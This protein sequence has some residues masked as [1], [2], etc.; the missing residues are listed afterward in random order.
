MKALKTIA[1]GSL[2]ILSGVTFAQSDDSVTI[3]SVS[4]APGDE[5]L[6]PVTVDSNTDGIASIDIDV[7]YDDSQLTPN[8]GGTACGFIDAGDDLD[9]SKHGLA[10]SE[11]SAGVLRVIVNTLPALGNPPVVPLDVGEVVVLRFEIQQGATAPGTILLEAS[12]TD[13]S[14][15]DGD[16]IAGVTFND[17][18][19]AVLDVGPAIGVDPTTIDFG[20]QEQNTTSSAESVRVTNTGNT[21]GLEISGV[22]F[23]GDAVFAL[24][25][26]GCD[27]L[28]LNEGAFCDI[29]FIFSPDD[30]SSFSGMATI[31]SNA[32]DFDVTLEGEGAPG[33][34]GD[35]TISV[36]H[37]FGE[38]LTGE[39][40][41]QHTFT[42][43][44][45]EAGG[46]VVAV[47]TVELAGDTDEF[48]I[49]SEDCDGASLAPGDTCTV[50]VEFEPTDDGSFSVTL[51]V[52][53]ED[54]NGDTRSDTADAAGTGVSEARFSSNPAPGNVD[55]G[56]AGAAGELDLDV[57]VTNSGND[58]LQLRC[59]IEENQGDVFTIDPLSLDVAAGESDSFNVA[60][61]LPDLA[62]YSATL[63]CGTNDPANT[64]VEYTFTCAGREPLPVPTMS[65]WSIALFAMLML[66]VGGISLRFFRT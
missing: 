5:V 34:A 40:S 14:D 54:G 13:A 39:E 10:C 38:L 42:V 28:S 37:A 22:S 46:S 43:S 53:G 6:V 60:C 29:S 18:E 56:F 35:I 8:A 23:S 44:N 62:T 48:T 7:V 50:T 66:L 2:L 32:G 58:E 19:V 4:G 11:P 27:G 21:D 65:N 9:T 47:D 55:L 16:T 15:T 51:T 24:S 25:S 30:I 41:A 59:T 1:A 57:T 20:A 33:P 52:S 63:S 3:G 49:V 12:G 26:N 17:G 36:D 61:D 64:T 45:T 31:E